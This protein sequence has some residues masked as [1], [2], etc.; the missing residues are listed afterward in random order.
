MEDRRIEVQLRQMIRELDALAR[1]KNAS[2]SGMPPPPMDDR[3]PVD[4]KPPDM[5]PPEDTPPM[6]MPPI[7]PAL[8]PDMHSP[9]MGRLLDL[10]CDTDGTA[11]MELARQ[12]RI[13]PQSLSELLF[14]ME[15]RG[16]VTRTPS[17]TDKRQSI[18]RIT[19]SG[20]E[21]ATEMRKIHECAA[22][23]LFAALDDGEKK[24]L[25]ALL[26]KVI[27]SGESAESE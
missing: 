1:R 21:K 3:P 13:R 26:Q 9:G 27:A 25:A 6:G 19:D 5:P 15:Q 2:L 14:R 4:D 16:Y 10:L 20:R 11:Q 17:E 12:L 7:N 23:T 8:P 24:T 22:I 18:V